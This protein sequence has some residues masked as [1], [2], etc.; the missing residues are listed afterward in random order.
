MLFFVQMSCIEETEIILQGDLEERLVVESQIT[1]DTTHHW[2][3]LS[4]TGQYYMN[5]QTPL[6]SGADVILSTDSGEDFL[7]EEVEPGLYKT[8][9]ETYGIIGERY[10][11]KIEYNGEIFESS[12]QIRRNATIDSI[13]FRYEPYME[14]Y[15][16]LYYGQEPPG[17]GDFYLWHLYKNGIHLTDSLHKLMFTDDEYFD[18]MF[19]PGFEVDSWA[20]NFDFQKDDTITVEMHSITQEAY[21]FILHVYSEVGGSGPMG[22]SFTTPVGNI[23]NDAFGLFYTASVVRKTNVIK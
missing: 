3:K 15:R 12:S 16:V 19:V 23:S 11:L 4:Q 20:G 14:S 7:F 8:I 10:S 5:E 9:N 6:L 22:G 13:G 18:G 1:T 17:V 2:V 21:D